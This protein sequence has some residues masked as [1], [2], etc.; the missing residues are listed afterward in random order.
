MTPWCRGIVVSWY[1][2]TVVSRVDFLEELGEKTS[3]TVYPVIL[4][5]V[6]NRDPGDLVFS[7]FDTT[8][9]I[10]IFDIGEMVLL[11]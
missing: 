11:I 1:H 9:L 4:N 7:G 10:S 2:D 8:P 5:K 6:V 3:L